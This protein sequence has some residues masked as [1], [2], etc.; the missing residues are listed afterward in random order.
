MSTIVIVHGAWGGSWAWRNFSRLLRGQGHEVFTPTLT[1]LGDRSHLLTPQIGLEHHIRDVAA[2]LEFEDLG[3]VVLVGH[4]YGGMVVTG[5]A[6]RVGERIAELIY[7]DAFV[8]R[9]GESVF[10][11]Q[12]AALTERMKQLAA[13]QADGRL[14]PPSPLAPDTPAA[15][16]VWMEKRR[17]P[18]PVPCFAEPIK[19]AAAPIARRSYI[20]CRRIGPFD[21]FGPFAAR[22][23]GDPAWRYYEMDAS[24]GPHITAPRELAAL[25]AD[26]IAG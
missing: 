12:P 16:R 10:D 13:E 18:Q 21:T 20:Y 1:G 7:L 25:I 24:H 23:K 14:I 17:M 15:E 22:A 26:I 5:V 9:D 19:L 2:V 11:L 8:P 6:D 4:S 3:D